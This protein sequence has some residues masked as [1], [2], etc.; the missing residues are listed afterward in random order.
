MRNQRS[1][2]LIVFVF[3]FQL[4]ICQA[5][6][7]SFER[8]EGITKESLIR[9]IKKSTSLDDQQIEALINTLT[10]QYKLRPE[11]R[12]PIKGYLYAAGMNGAMLLDHDVWYFDA[13]LID[14]ATQEIVKIPEL[15]LCDFHNGG[16]KFEVAYK[17]MFT[18]IPSGVNVDELHGAVYGR[19]VGLVADAFFGAEGSWMPAKNRAN[20]LLHVAL[21]I[22]FGGGVVFPKMEFKLRQ[23][24]GVTGSAQ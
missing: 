8:D 4:L 22:G 6:A 24:N 21:K 23:I 10:L 16:I 12:I 1:M 5:F 19:G 9:S 14:P 15:F 3:G 20:D 18:F 11:Q 17:W 13:N 2:W 7:Q